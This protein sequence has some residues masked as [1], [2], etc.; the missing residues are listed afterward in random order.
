MTGCNSGDARNRIRELPG[1]QKDKDDE[2]KRYR[3]DG[4]PAT[5]AVVAAAA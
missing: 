5:A 4:G 2:T 1:V 3:P